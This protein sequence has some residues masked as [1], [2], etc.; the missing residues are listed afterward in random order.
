MTATLICIIYF[1]N[2]YSGCPRYLDSTA[3][4]FPIKYGSFKYRILWLLSFP[5]IPLSISF[6]FS[7]KI[8]LLLGPRSVCVH[9]SLY[10]RFHFSASSAA[11]PFSK[12]FASFPAIPS[13]E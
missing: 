5:C 3:G 11:R 1:L 7:R 9:I 2:I 8:S 12:A 13:K 10:K 4:P 6:I